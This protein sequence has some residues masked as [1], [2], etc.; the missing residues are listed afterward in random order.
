MLT[1]FDT[2]HPQS[3]FKSGTNSVIAVWEKNRTAPNGAWLNRVHPAL[4]TES[5][6]LQKGVIRTR[7]APLPMHTSP[8]SSILK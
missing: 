5:P 4:N 3:S 1:K 6:P 2:F 7:P 8:F